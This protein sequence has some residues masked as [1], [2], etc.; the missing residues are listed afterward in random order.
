MLPVLSI[1]HERS[2]ARQLAVE[3][4]QI[5]LLTGLTVSN[6]AQKIIGLNHQQAVNI[7]AGFD[8]YLITNFIGFRNRLGQFLYILQLT[9]RINGNTERIYCWAWP[10]ITPR[11]NGKIKSIFTAS[12]DIN[13]NVSARFRYRTTP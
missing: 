7:G 2:Q 3:T 4:G 1:S 5:S 9:Q 12:R 8:R 10:E 11:V 6:D 13:M